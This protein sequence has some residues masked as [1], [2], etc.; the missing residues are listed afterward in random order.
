MQA[1]RKRG[2]GKGAWPR[3]SPRLAAAA[4][5]TVAVWGVAV[6]LR[7]TT[8]PPYHSLLCISVGWVDVVV[9]QMEVELELVFVENP[10][11]AF[12]VVSM[13][14]RHLQG[15]AQAVTVDQN[16]ATGILVGK[17]S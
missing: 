16:I 3:I 14:R 1:H 7:M 9:E 11:V 5:Q 13:M 15:T 12:G 10:F 6:V 2:W 8:K 17:T 4:G